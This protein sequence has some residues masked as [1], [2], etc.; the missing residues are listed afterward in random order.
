MI[1]S[2]HSNTIPNLIRLFGITD[3]ITISDDQ[4]GDLFQ[5][6]WQDGK[7]ILTITQVGQ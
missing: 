7:P 5:I 1:I 6:E 4:Y 3:E 2:G